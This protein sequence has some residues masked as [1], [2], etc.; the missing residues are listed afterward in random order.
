[1]DLCWKDLIIGINMFCVFLYIQKKPHQK[2]DTQIIQFRSV[3]TNK[4]FIFKNLKY[5]VR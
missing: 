4:S 1:M 2:T 3:L 5:T